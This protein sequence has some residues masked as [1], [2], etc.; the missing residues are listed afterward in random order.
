MSS[1]ETDP[2]SGAERQQPGLRRGAV[3]R[4][5][6]R[7]QRGGRALARV[8]RV[9][10][11]QLPAPRPRRRPFAPRRPDG[12]RRHAA[13]AAGR[14]PRT[15]PSRPR[16]TG[17]SRPTAS[18]ATCAPTSTRSALTRRAEPARAGDVR[19]LGGRPRPALR[20]PGGPPGPT[21]RGLVARLEE[22]YCRTLGRRARAHARRRPARLARAADGAD[23]QPRA[24]STPDVKKRAPREDRRGGDA[25]AVPRDEV[26]RRE[27]LQR[28]RAPRASCRCSSSLV[29]RAVGHGVRNVVIGMAHRG[30]LNVLANVVGKPLRD[31]LRRVPRRRDHRT[32]AAAT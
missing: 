26:P 16:S 8:L 17:W 4:V 27:A 11:E 30:R 1:P 15:P 14:G 19:P 21:L 3:L 23:A 7:S 13:P 9:A 5:A 12:E 2:R 20:R 25:R 28:S 24:R 31:D 29:D 6:R 10:A 18:T 32:P 22:T